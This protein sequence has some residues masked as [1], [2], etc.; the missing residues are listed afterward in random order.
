MASTQAH[1][2]FVPECHVPCARA[3][4][5]AHVCTHTHTHTHTNA[6]EIEVRSPAQV[7]LCKSS[8]VLYIKEANLSCATSQPWPVSLQP[9]ATLELGPP[10]GPGT[11]S[12]LPVIGG[13]VLCA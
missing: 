8:S 5:R 4:A 1:G 13:A 2:L 7:S 3:R 10:T 6:K 11:F 12:G 9:E